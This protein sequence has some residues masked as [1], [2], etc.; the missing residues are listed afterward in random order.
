MKYITFYVFTT[1][2]TYYKVQLSN[3]LEL[4]SLINLVEN[5]KFVLN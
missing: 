3:T 5:V 2:G 4:N 1:F